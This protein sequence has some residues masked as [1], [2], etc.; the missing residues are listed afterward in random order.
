MA[1]KTDRP[2]DTNELAKLI[3]DIATGDVEDTEK[4][5]QDLKKAAAALLGRAG[6][7]RGGKARA[8]KLSPER[9]AE[10][11]KNAAAKRWQ[12]PE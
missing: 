8:A 11:A 6:G 3:T 2:K 10:I 5:Q 12:K 4:Q 7:L 9:R 1:K